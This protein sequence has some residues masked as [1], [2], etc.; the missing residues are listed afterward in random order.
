MYC[1]PPSVKFTKVLSEGPPLSAFIINTFFSSVQTGSVQHKLAAVPYKKTS[2]STDSCASSTHTCPLRT[3]HS[4]V[5]TYHKEIKIF[6]KITKTDIFF[7]FTI[8]RF[9]IWTELRVAVIWQTSTQNCNNPGVLVAPCLAVTCV[10]GWL[11]GLIRKAGECVMAWHWLL[12]C[13]CGR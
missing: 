5:R 11:W 13:S 10:L 2:S 1:G 9:L 7:K 4:H 3:P 8:P 12:T 6:F